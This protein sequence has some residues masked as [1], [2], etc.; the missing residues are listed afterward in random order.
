MPFDGTPRPRPSTEEISRAYES[1]VCLEEFFDGGRKWHRG[2][3]RDGH[4][5]VCLIGAI[6]R[7]RCDDLTLRYLVRVARSRHERC[8]FGQPV[9]AVMND[10]C[11]NFEEVRDCLGEA[12]ALA[13]A[14]LVQSTRSPGCAGAHDP[15]CQSP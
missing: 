10:H 6:D 7:L 9:I 14:D 8:P 15:A 4:G 13:A 11:G 5:S 2:E 3:L 1:L 12:R